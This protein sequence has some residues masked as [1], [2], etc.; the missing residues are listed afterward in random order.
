MKNYNW[1]SGFNMETGEWE[2]MLW[3][4]AGEKTLV[5]PAIDG[6]HSWNAG[7]YSPKTGLFY[8][9]ANEWCMYLTVNTE[10]AAA[11]RRPRAPRPARPS[12]SRS[13]SWPRKWEGTN[14]PGDKVHGR[15][16]AR[17]PVTGDLAWE[18]RYDI[19]P[20]S[21][22][23]STARRPAV[24]RHLRRLARGAWT[25]RTATCSGASISAPAPMAAS[26]PMTPAA[27]STSR[28]RPATAR[29]SAGRWRATTTKT[30]S[31]TTRKSRCSSPSSR[32]LA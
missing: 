3:P 2:N 18:K 27:S 25:P 14:P 24:Q 11:R 12:R 10:G 30:S 32:R 15:I 23:L 4:I 16:T 17:D 28:W 8:R 29:T 6:G 20:H 19:I 26:S 31:S 7:T 5:C 22:L 21:A 9:I 13:P 1:T